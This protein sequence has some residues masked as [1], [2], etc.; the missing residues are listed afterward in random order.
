MIVKQSVPIN[1]S[2]GI[3]TKTDPYQVQIGKFLSLQNSV[4]TKGGLLQKRNGYGPLAAL[5]NAQSVYATTLNGS[6]TA[7]GSNVLAYSPSN[8][9]WVNKGKFQNID[10]SSIPVGRSAVNQT[11]CDSVVSP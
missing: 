4:F 11:Q 1:F 9:S 6:L 2:Q 3:D 8:S 10:F 7:I 5:P